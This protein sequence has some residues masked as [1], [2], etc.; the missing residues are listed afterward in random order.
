MHAAAAGC[1]MR[2]LFVPFV[3]VF[4][5]PYSTYSVCASGIRR[6]IN[7]AANKINSA[8]G[9]FRILWFKVPPKLLTMPLYEAVGY[10][11]SRV[12][13]KHTHTHTPA[14]ENSRV[15]QTSTNLLGCHLGYYM[16]EGCTL[17]PSSVLLCFYATLLCSY[18]SMYHWAEPIKWIRIRWRTRSVDE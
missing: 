1:T 13:Q 14:R 3:Y 18:A 7:A 9:I 16:Y 5:T 12:L 6:M 8:Q 17:H 4:I 2:F 10:T 15:K 11:H